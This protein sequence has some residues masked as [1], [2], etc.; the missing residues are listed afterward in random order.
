VKNSFPRLALLCSLAAF[1]SAG[2]AQQAQQPPTPDATPATVEPPLKSTNKDPFFF[3]P[4][5]NK[6]T[7]LVEPSKIHLIHMGGNDCPPCVAW[8]EVEL[9]KL[10][11][12]EVFRSIRFSY[13]IKTISS[14]VP[15]SLFL[16]SEVQPLKEKLD[17]AGGGNGGSPQQVLIVNDEVYDYWWKPRTA[18]EIERMIVALESGT[19]YPFLRCIRRAK[20]FACLDRG[21]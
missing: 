17:I 14:P 18:E 11:A 8:R 5:P 7:H 4:P 19:P 13:V 15:S 3:V 10:R 1:F 12:S 9:P 20:G 16:P 6:S 21:G 2:F